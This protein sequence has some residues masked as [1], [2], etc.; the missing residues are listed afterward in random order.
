[1]IEKY[2]LQCRNERARAEDLTVIK[3]NINLS[4]YN[5]LL[6]MRCNFGLLGNI[7]VI[8]K[9]ADVMHE[10]RLAP[11]DD[12]HLSSI[13]MCHLSFRISLS[14]ISTICNISIN[15]LQLNAHAWWHTTWTQH[16]SAKEVS[17]CEWTW[18]LQLR[19]NED[20]NVKEKGSE[21]IEQQRDCSW[22]GG[23]AEKT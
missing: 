10:W 8:V 11:H 23:R 14:S 1:M 22:K 6:I 3:I 5:V 19:E 20:F 7:N 4:L 9:F 12:Y 17:Q 21:L 18:S 16:N 13:Y 15:D 2:I